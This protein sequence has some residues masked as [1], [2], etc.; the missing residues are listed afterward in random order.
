MQVI[1]YATA[2]EM[3]ED[4][5]D[6]EGPVTVAGIEFN[7]ST[8]LRECDPVAYRC[9]LSDYISSLEEDDWVI[10]D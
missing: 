8:I 5:L 1:D 6:C 10:E 7:R 2:V 3:F 4:A 9:Y